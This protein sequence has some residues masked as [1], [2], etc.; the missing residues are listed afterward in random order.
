METNINF[1]KGIVMHGSIVLVISCLVMASSFARVPAPL[2]SVVQRDDVRGL[3]LLLK[4]T[5]IGVN[6]VVDRIYGYTMLHLAAKSNKVKIMRWLI[7]NGAEVD[8]KSGYKKASPMGIAAKYGH[9]EAMG[10]LLDSNAKLTSKIEM[11]STTH[12]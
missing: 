2:Q 12:H 5:N 6:S 9:V 10:V 7:D 11:S 3:A 4:H 1:L 8:I